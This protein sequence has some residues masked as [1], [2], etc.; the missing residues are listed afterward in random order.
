MTLAALAMSLGSVTALPMLDTSTPASTVAISAPQMLVRS[1]LANGYMS[2]DRLSA[3][4]EL[5]ARSPVDEDQA[6]AEQRGAEPVEDPAWEPQEFVR[7][8]RKTGESAQR[9]AS[10]QKHGSPEDLAN[11]QQ[12]HNAA[13]HGFADQYENMAQMLRGFV[14]E[15]ENAGIGRPE[16]RGYDIA[17]PA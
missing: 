8:F 17:K 12:E 6:Q 4:L 7:A 5:K 2:R 16:G 1:N 9:E 11:A 15:R 3:P 10:L 13:L 14:T